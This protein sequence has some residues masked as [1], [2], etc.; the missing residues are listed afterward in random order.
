MIQNVGSLKQS[1]PIQKSSFATGTMGCVQQPDDGL[2]S[3]FLGTNSGRYRCF[4]SKYT[5]M[6]AKKHCD[7]SKSTIVTTSPVFAHL[8]DDNSRKLIKPEERRIEFTSSYNRTIQRGVQNVTETSVA[9]CRP[10]ARESSEELY[11]QEYCISVF[12]LIKLRFL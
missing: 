6:K 10:E 2:L 5:H 9:V 3:K 12:L 1:N 11:Q 7:V 4:P 8:K